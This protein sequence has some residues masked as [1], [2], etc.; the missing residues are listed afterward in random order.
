ME[1]VIAGARGLAKGG[2]PSA[3]EAG[4]CSVGL[5]KGHS[6]MDCYS[7]HS[8]NG[9]EDA[10]FVQFYPTLL[11]VTQKKNTLSAA[12]VKEKANRG[13][14]TRRRNKAHILCGS[15]IVVVAAVL[16]LPFCRSPLRRT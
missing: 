5:R 15:R 11:E 1:T 3:M 7:C 8:Q 4:W 2:V 10:T 9:A 16:S 13:R 6:E 14:G 12:H